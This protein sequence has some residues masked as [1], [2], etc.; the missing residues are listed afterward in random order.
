MTSAMSS[1]FVAVLALVAAFAC[2]PMYYVV[3]TVPLARP[4]PSGCVQSAATQERLQRVRQLRYPDSTSALEAFAGVM[5][6][7]G[8]DSAGA[9][10]GRKLLQIRDGCGGSGVPGG[11]DYDIKT[12]LR[13]PH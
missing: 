7:P 11:P 6:S 1:R 5:V 2:D 4:I 10:V 3:V 8:I 13:A 12:S 9:R